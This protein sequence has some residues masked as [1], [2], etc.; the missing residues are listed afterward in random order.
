M[1]K[2]RSL[3]RLATASTVAGAIGWKVYTKD[4]HFID[5]STSSPEFATAFYRAHNPAPGNKPLLLDHAVKRVPLSKLRTSDTDELTREFSANI[6]GGPGF[7]LQRKYHEKRGRHLEGRQDMLWE[8][9]D[10]A[11]SDYR[12]GTK[13]ADYFE[14]VQRTPEKVTV[15]W[16]DSPLVTGPRPSDGLFSVEVS[17]DDKFATFH[18]KSIFFNSTPEGAEG[19]QL[20]FWYT[21][22]HREY[23]KLWM[24]TSVRSLMK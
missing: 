13:I 18:L 14:V 8:K 23:T 21:P 12:Q 3:V 17:R 2:F 4:T 19:G 10:L 15:R 20:P 24:E 16:G 5:F 11:K 22:L 6:W 9:G 1:G 7:A